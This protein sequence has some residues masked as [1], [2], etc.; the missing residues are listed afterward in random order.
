VSDKDIRDIAST[1]ATIAPTA[2]GTD[3]ART[4]APTAGA[5]LPTAD[6]LRIEKA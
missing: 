2:L 1:L 3:T 5:A 4:A 6:H